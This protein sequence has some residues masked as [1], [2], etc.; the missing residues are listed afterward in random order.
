[1]AVTSAIKRALRPLG[2][3]VNMSACVH[4]FG[5]EPITNIVFEI[6]VRYLLTVFIPDPYRRAHYCLTVNM[7]TMFYS[8]GRRT[9]QNVAK[10]RTPT[11]ALPKTS[12]QNTISRTWAST[13]NRKSLHLSSL[14]GNFLTPLSTNSTISIR[15]PRA[16]TGENLECFSCGDLDDDGT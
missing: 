2:L 10:G 7:R 9:A 13:S 6:F 3:E 16:L 5:K 12:L 1:L 11:T 4:G 14:S 15:S 8:I